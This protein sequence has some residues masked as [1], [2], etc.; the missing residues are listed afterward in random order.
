CDFEVFWVFQALHQD[1]VLASRE[2]DLEEIENGCHLVG[3]VR[4]VTSTLRENQ[5]ELFLRGC[6]GCEVIAANHELLAVL[7][8]V[9]RFEEKG[10]CPSFI[11][12]AIF[13]ATPKTLGGTS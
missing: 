9:C 8:L 10:Y 12:D 7:I 6:Y 4:V 2:R 11:G 1:A 3:D 5:H 13:D